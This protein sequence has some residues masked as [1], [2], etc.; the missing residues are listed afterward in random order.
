M[1]AHI[2][3]ITNLKF[4]VKIHNSFGDIAENVNITGRGDR[5]WLLQNLHFELCN[6]NERT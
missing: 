6:S 4:H 3:L 5:G 2:F 1:K